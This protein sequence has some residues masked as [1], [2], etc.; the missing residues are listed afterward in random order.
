MGPRM[1][2]RGATGYVSY[3][4]TVWRLLVVLLLLCV[5]CGE[6]PCTTRHTLSQ[7]TV[8]SELAFSWTTLATPGTTR[9]PHALAPSTLASGHG[10]LGLRQGQRMSSLCWMCLEAWAKPTEWR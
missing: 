8:T 3:Q 10:T 9:W 2:A 5:P 7:I 6:S 1:K 4:C